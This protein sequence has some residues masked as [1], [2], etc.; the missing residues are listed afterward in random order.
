MLSQGEVVYVA[1][2]RA[3]REIGIQSQVG[4]RHP[5]HCTALGKVMLAD[6]TDE[7]VAEI[8]EGCEMAALTEHTITSVAAFLAELA[9]VRLRGYAIDNEERSY[10]VKCIAAPIRDVHGR[11]IGAISVS[12]PAF[13][14]SA[15]TLP[16]LIGAVT[17]AAASIS[18]RQGYRGAA[19]MADRR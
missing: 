15:E 9:H 6:L 4:T 14:V 12:G 17:D 2:E 13:R 7:Q 1:I 3:Q 11:V 8:L 5:S 16:P 19:Q 18:R 10:G